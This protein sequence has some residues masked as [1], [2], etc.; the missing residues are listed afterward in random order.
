METVSISDIK[1]DISGLI[2]RVAF[3]RERIVLT[4]RGRPKAGLVSVADLLRLDQLDRAEA[5][6]LQEQELAK[7]MAARALQ[8]RI[9]A[10]TGELLPD[11][12]EELRE[13]REERDEYLSGLR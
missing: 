8:E 6:G 2:N 13:L 10:R 4:S 7:L 11:S 5:A 9:L 12:A 3:G 1:K